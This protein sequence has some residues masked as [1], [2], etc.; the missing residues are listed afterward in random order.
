MIALS[1][2]VAPGPLLRSDAV[3]APSPA[4]FPTAASPSGSLVLGVTTAALAKKLDH[5]L[6][7]SGPRRGQWL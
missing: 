7:D 6:D 2:V 5:A 1:A 3:I 4:P